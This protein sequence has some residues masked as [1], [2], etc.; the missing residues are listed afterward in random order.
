MDTKGK[1]YENVGVPVDYELNYDRDRQSFFRY[2][3]N[4][5]EKDK[6]EILEAIKFL[7]E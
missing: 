4:N 1:E 5:L 6:K 3:V 2:I 7:E